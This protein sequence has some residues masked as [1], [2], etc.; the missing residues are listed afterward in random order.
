MIYADDAQRLDP[1]PPPLVPRI[2]VIDELYEAVILDRPPVHSGEW[3]LATT[4]VCLA[5]LQSARDQAEVT[6]R[7]QVGLPHRLKA[8]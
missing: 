1:L 5:M 8:T 6:L 2:E 3:A 4:E 7:H